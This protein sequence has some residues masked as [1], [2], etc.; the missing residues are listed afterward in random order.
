MSDILPFPQPQPDLDIGVI[1]TG[2]RD[3]IEPL[4]GSLRESGDGLRV[5]LLLV[6]NVSPD[7]A[8]N[9]DRFFAETLVLRNQRRLLYTANLNR[10][11]RASRA[12]YVLLLNT[13]MLFD[14][15]EQCLRRMT[16]FMEQHPGCGVAGCRLYRP[17]GRFAHPAR[18][19]QTLPTIVARRLGLGRWMRR[20][21]DRYL[22]RDRA[23]E[24]TFECDWLS[25]CFLMVRRAAFED[26][27]SF[28]ERFTKYFEDVDLCL[29][30][31]RAG[32]KVMYH[33]GVYALHLERRSS[34]KIFSRD[35][36]RHLRSYLRWLWKWG[37]APDPHDFAPPLRRAA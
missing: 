7:G 28:D 31:A 11:L 5:R 9:L 33:G 8:E 2:E 30:M 32:W 37:F 35:A 18:R 6:D 26:I 29:R 34:R 14:P 12:R 10:V 24:D 21:L 16:A 1:Y 13:D 15:S 3:L 20:T 19:F 4:L 17:D 23:V 25:G 36:Y 22:Y 27:G